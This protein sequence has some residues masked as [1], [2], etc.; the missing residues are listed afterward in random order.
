MGPVKHSQL[1]SQRQSGVSR[2]SCGPVLTRNSATLH[3]ERLLEFLHTN[4]EM[5]S[6]LLILTHDFPDPDARRASARVWGH[7]S[8]A[9]LLSSGHISE[10]YR[11]SFLSASM[12]SVSSLS[13]VMEG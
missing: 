3:G 1:V 6:P 5:L 2:I 11:P 7:W 12:I 10:P 4:R 13:K 8:A 9:T